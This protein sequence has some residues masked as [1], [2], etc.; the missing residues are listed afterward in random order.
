MVRVEVL[1]A[2]GGETDRDQ[3]RREERPGRGDQEPEEGGPGAHRE[4]AAGRRA[5]P[6]QGDLRVGVIG[7]IHPDL[8]R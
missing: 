1:D 3:D 4:F 7:G 8:R 5:Q 2:R 6:G